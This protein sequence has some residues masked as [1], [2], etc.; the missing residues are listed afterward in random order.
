[1]VEA[2]VDRVIGLGAA[3]VLLERQPGSLGL[4]AK[5]V[6]CV[7][8]LQAELLRDQ[9]R[10]RRLAAAGQAGDRDQ[11]AAIIAASSAPL[12]PAAGAERGGAGSSRTGLSR[13]SSGPHLRVVD[14]LVEPSRVVGISRSR[15]ASSGI[16]RRSAP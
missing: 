14:A 12:H 7:D 10:D 16:T 9:A 4:P 2:P 8:V 15:T 5:E 1:V 6:A 11:H 3:G 13:A